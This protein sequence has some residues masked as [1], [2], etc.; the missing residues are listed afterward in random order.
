MNFMFLET[1]KISGVTPKK[2]PTWKSL[3]E[4]KSFLQYNK[5]F[6]SILAFGI[7]FKGIKDSCKHNLYSSNHQILT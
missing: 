2:C 6:S 4:F 7:D 1:R 3:F 5:V